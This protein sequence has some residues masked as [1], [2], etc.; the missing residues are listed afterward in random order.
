MND[1]II[2]NELSK[3]RNVFKELLSGLTAEM[4]LWMPNPGK[5]CL[6]E[7][8]CHLYDIEREDFRARTKHVLETPAAPL[9]RPMP[10]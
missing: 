6:L 8:V 2:I 5:W 9:P 7:I 4:Y 1:T 10:G 3:N